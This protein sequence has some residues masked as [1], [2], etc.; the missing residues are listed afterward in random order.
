MWAT[1]P[2]I[3][4]PTVVIVT[5]V[6]CL[7]KGQSAESTNRDALH[8][9]WPPT[10]LVGFSTLFSEKSRLHRSQ[11]GDLLYTLY[12]VCDLG[13]AMKLQSSFIAINDCGG[14]ELRAVEMVRRAA[15][16]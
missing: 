16:E 14:C 7:P 9:S 1:I 4:R 6:I 2:E 5:V 13:G 3:Q 11:V 10:T 15:R 8:D 12:C